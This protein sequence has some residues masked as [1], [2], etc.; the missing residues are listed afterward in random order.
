MISRA[1]RRR[2][3]GCITPRAGDRHDRAASYTST[4]T[5]CAAC[6][7]KAASRRRAS[8]RGPRCSMP[9]VPFIQETFARY[10]TL[11][12]SRLYRMVR[13]RGYVG[14]PRS[15]P[16]HGGPMATAAGGRSVS[17]LAH[18][19]RRT[20][21]DRLGALRQAYDR[22]RA[23]AADGLRDGALLLAPSVRA[24]LL[25]RG[26]AAAS[27]TLTCRPSPTSMAVP[28]VC[29][30][31]NLAQR[32]ARA[33][34]AMRSALTR[35]CSSSPPGIASSRGRWRWPAATR[36]AGSSARSASFASASLRPA[37]SPMWPISTPRRSLGAAGE[38]AERP[39]PEDR[40][41]SVRECFEEERPRLLSVAG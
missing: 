18:L 37:A 4:T 38:A 15:L 40:T 36:R 19:A 2:S 12:A 30:Y 13:E 23:A 28:R 27:W 8:A 17:A 21:T 24:I 34:A 35:R 22:P 41:R 5:P 14:Q 9:I 29:L 31:D 20:S 10:P 3:C 39:C 33:L 25:E 7:G 26:D 16:P 6:C 11:R 1:S 32:R